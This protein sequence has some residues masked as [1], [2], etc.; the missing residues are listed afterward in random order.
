M[1]KA[2]KRLVPEFSGEDKRVK[3]KELCFESHQALLEAEVVS[4]VTVV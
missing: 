4:F 1:T 3:L 2:W